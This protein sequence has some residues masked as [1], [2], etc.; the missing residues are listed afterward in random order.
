MTESRFWSGPEAHPPGAAPL[1]R[2]HPAPL[3]LGDGGLWSSATD[4]LR[5][6]QAMNRDELGVSALVQAPGR[7]DDGTVLSYAWAVDVRE[8]AGLRLHRHGGSWTGLSAQLVR[9][10]DLG[11]GFVIIAPDDDEVRTARLVTG[12]LDELV[13]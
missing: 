12:L 10:P 8:H 7:L 4:L 1:D 5:W 6:N 9:V 11:I 2:Q 3:S 13:G